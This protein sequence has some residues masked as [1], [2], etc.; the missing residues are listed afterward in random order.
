MRYHD[1]SSGVAHPATL[2]GRRER[3]RRIAVATNAAPWNTAGLAPG[4]YLIVVWPRAV[5]ND[6]FFGGCN[7]Q[8][9]VVE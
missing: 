9:Y 1:G 7:W 2:C 8:Y 5:G 6:T 3:A 4:S